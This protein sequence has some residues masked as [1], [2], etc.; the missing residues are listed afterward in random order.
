VKRALGRLLVVGGVGV[1][2]AVVLRRA[3]RRGGDVAGI[4]TSSFDV[5]PPVPPAP[6]GHGH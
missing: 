2:A 4:R 1:G 3:V 5:W 6:A